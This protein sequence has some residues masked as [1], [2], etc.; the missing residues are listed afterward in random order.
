MLEKD[1]GELNSHWIYFKDGTRLAVDLEMSCENGFG[2]F[3]EI[4]DAMNEGRQVMIFYTERPSLMVSDESRSHSILVALSQ[5][6][7]IV[8]NRE[9]YPNA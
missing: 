3:K 8:P 7:A 9:D 5:I 2:D 6:K 1:F 4:H